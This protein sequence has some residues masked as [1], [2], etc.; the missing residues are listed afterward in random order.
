MD[1]N[2]VSCRYNRSKKCI[3]KEKRT[4]CLEVSKAVLCLGDDLSDAQDKNRADKRT[5]Y[6]YKSSN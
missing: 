3:N 2:L 5:L 4:E 1:C 6:V